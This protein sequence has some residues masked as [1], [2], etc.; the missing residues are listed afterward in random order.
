MVRNFKME[1]FNSFTLHR[2]IIGQSA[3]M[4]VRTS[5]LSRNGTTVAPLLRCRRRRRRPPPPPPPL[6]LCHA[7][8]STTRLTQ[9][10]STC[11]EV[12][13]CA[14]SRFILP[15]RPTLVGPLEWFQNTFPKKTMSDPLEDPLEEML[16]KCFIKQF[17]IDARE[18]SGE[19]IVGVR[20]IMAGRYRGVPTERVS[21]RR[22][23]PAKSTN[24]SLP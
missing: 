2:K 11:S 5:V 24:V 18:F 10:F 3:T 16:H 1:H 8:T 15:A 23:L 9:R 21:E 13:M 22:S 12:L 19:L 7:L 17:M 14:A 20:R 4:H 6:R